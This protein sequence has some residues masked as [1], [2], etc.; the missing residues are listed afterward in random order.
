MDTTT[1]LDHGIV[2][3][4]TDFC[5]VLSIVHTHC[6]TNTQH[7]TDVIVTMVTSVTH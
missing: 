4:Q 6:I 3:H 1:L 2:F 5:A 7:I